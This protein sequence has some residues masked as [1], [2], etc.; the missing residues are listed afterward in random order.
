MLIDFVNLLISVIANTIT[1]TFALLPA[2]PFKT[3]SN[4]DV[5]S[6]LGGLSWIIPFPSIITELGLFIT[7]VLGYYGVMI[8]LRWIKAIE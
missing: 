1:W 5:T 8:I 3:I 4:T 2:S 7:G 6:F